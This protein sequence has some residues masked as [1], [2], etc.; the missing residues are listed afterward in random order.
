[1]SVPALRGELHAIVAGLEAFPTGTLG[2]AGLRAAGVLRRVLATSEAV[3]AEAAV[4]R[5][6]L[7]GLGVEECAARVRGGMGALRTYAAAL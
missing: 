2:Q 6:E 3:S 7:A 1:M 5:I 4:R